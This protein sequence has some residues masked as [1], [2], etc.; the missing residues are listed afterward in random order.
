MME[1]GLSLSVVNFLKG[2]VSVAMI[3]FGHILN[4]CLGSRVA[5]FDATMVELAPSDIAR[6]IGRMLMTPPWMTMT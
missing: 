2:S 3:A 4:G 5:V 6:L 1:E